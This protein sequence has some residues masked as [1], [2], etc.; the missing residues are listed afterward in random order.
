MI[1][2]LRDVKP[3]MII[4]NAGSLELTES[5]VNRRDLSTA[6][7]SKVTYQ[8]PDIFKIYSEAKHAVD[9]H[10]RSRQGFMLVFD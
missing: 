10:N 8:R 9:D 4:F 1:T 7:K 5:Q 3:Q 6:E 2:A